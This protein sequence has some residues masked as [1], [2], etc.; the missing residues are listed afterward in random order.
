MSRGK[1]PLSVALSVLAQITYQTL[2]TFSG[3]LTMG[4]PALQ[5]NA[6][7]NSG[8]LT[9]TPLMRYFE[10]EWGSVAARSRSS[11]GRSLAQSHWAKPIKKRCSG[12]S[13]SIGRRVLFLVASFHA[14]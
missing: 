3:G 10:G 5:E 1:L 4:W 6:W 2:Q 7:V 14:I 13:P 12:V 8:M 9:T 11:S